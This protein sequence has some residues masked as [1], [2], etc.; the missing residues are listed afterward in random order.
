M[1]RSQEKIGYLV[2]C[3]PDGKDGLPDYNK[4][5]AFICKGNQAVTYGVSTWHAPMIALGD[6]DYL[7]FAVLV[8]ENGVP[9]EDCE[10]VTYNPGLIVEF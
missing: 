10:E 8:H 6:E 7:D 4:V 5:E 2:I 3:A 9:E 1:G